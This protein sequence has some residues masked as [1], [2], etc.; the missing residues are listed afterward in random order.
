M[1]LRH[2]RLALLLL[3]L[4]RAYRLP[5]EARSAAAALR[6]AEAAFTTANVPE[7]RLSAEHLLAAATGATRRSDALLRL[8]TPLNGVPRTRFEEMCAARLARTPVQYIV[9]EWDFHDLTL[10]LAPPVLIPRPETEELV[11][12]VLQAVR[13]RAPAESAAGDELR[14]L[15]I[16]CGSGAIG[17]ALLHQLRSATCVGLDVSEAAVALALANAR[18]LTLEGRYEAVLEPGGIGALAHEEPNAASAAALG[19][20]RRF[21]LIVSNP[22]YIP[23]AD[24]AALAAEVA[25]YEDE[26]ALCG[27]EDGLDVIREIVRAAPRLLRPEGGR[28]IWLE[29][30]T[31]HPQALREWLAQPHGLATGVKFMRWFPDLSGNPR[32]CELQWDGIT[33]ASGP[34]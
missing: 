14:L 24:M 32:F 30:D 31:S 20:P 6:A 1:A 5:A 10:T 13:L 23:R 33:G 7:P 2:H 8:S 3:P 19:L 27:G 28:S 34:R 29:V 21:D 16:G 11:E 4:S 18:R 9:G 12:L 17:L 15:D 26:R 25:D 22:P